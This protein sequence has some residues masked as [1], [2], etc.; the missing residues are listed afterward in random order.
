MEPT[1][2]SIPTST[3]VISLTSRYPAHMHVANILYEH[4]IDVTPRQ[5]TIKLNYLRVEAARPVLLRR[6]IEL[7]ASYYNQ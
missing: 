3:A 5:R 7:K 4:R 6:I 2:I 1:T